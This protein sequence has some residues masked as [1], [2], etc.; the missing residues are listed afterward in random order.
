MKCL[1]FIPSKARPEVLSSNALPFAKRTGLDYRIF[2]EPQD[3]QAY[4]MAN[5][6][7]L[8]ENDRGLGYAT[9]SAK[10]YAVKN[11]YDLM[12]KVDDDVQAIGNVEQDL[13]RLIK[14]FEIPAVGAICF[15]YS[16]EFYAKTDKLFTRVN[17]RVQTCYMIRTEAFSPSPQVSTFED[18]YQFLLLR[19]SGY[20]TLY[21]SKH[22]IKCKP[23]GGGKGGLQMFDRKEMAKREIAIFQSI[24]PSIAVISKPDKPWGYEPKFTGPKYKSR[25]L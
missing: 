23:V 2:V 14:A 16:F 11:G 9:S 12:F 17:K 15:P 20:D 21:C 7:H 4:T 24:D 8:K 10:E 22:S 18:F 5:V 13:Q 3:A 1:L 25:P 19:Q 6:V